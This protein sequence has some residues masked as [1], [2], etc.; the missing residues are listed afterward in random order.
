MKPEW[1]APIITLF[2]IGLSVALTPWIGIIYILLVHL[3]VWAWYKE[4]LGLEDYAIDMLIYLWEYSL[5]FT[6]MFLIGYGAAYLIL[7]LI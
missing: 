7:T 4:Y 5:I 3:A 2:V 1:F 6:A